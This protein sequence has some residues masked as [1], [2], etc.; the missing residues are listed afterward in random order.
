VVVLEKEYYP[1]H[2]VCGEYISLE[3]RPFLESLGYPVDKM[4]LP[5]IKHLLVSAPNGNTIEHPLPLGG[6]GIS[7]YKID[8][9]LAQLARRNGVEVLEGARVTDAVLYGPS[10]RVT[11]TGLSLDARVVVGAWGKRG[12]LDVKWKRDFAHKKPGRLNQFIGVKYHIKTDFPAD[13]IALHNFSGGYCGISKVENDTCCLCYLTTAQN[14]RKAGG[15]IDRM[16]KE[17]LCRNPR[18]AAVF[19]SSAFLWEEPLTIAQV[20]FARKRQIEN[21]VLM[22]GDTAGMIAPLCGNGMS[23]ALHASKLAAPLISRFLRRQMTRTQMEEEYQRQWTGA[24]ASR[25]RAGRFI[26]GLFG[27]D[28]ISNTFIGIMKPFP[29]LVSYLIRQTHGQPF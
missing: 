17:I 12:N 9:D 14:L 20:S 13:S 11:A 26:Q 19:A 7:R 21:H 3:S 23:M 15:S 8:A 5:L 28:H 24:F 27:N 2:R 25:L 10:F 16:E 29:K 22:S 18:L 1:F 4:D 6:F